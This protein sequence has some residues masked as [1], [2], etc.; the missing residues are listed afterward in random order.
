MTRLRSPRRTTRRLARGPEPLGQ[1]GLGQSSPRPEATG[2]LPWRWSLGPAPPIDSGL[3][4]SNSSES[5]VR[6]GQHG[7]KSGARTSRGRSGIYAVGRGSTVREERIIRVQRRQEGGW[8][9]TPEAVTAVENLARHCPGT[10]DGRP[11]TSTA[12]RAARPMLLADAR[13]SPPMPVGGSAM[14]GCIVPR[15]R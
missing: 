14:R 6:A 13:E 10:E 8:H 1:V 2:W 4:H 5:C 7:L 3:S 15:G 12:P 11:A 9:A